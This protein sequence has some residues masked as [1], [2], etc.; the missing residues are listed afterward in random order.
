LRP[1]IIAD[2]GGIVADELVGERGQHAQDGANCGNP[3]TQPHGL[4]RGLIVGWRRHMAIL[5][6]K[7]GTFERKSR[8]SAGKTQKTLDE[9]APACDKSSTTQSGETPVVLRF[10]DGAVCVRVYEGSRPPQRAA[11][12]FK[13]DKAAKLKSV[14]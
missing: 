2:D 14:A 13:S 9:I 10:S 1:R 4:K 5:A 11:V 7:P 3:R 12:L 6:G 8:N